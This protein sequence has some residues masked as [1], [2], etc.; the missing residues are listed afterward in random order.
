[1]HYWG[2]STKQLS[3]TNLIFSKSRFY[4]FKKH[5]GFL[6]AFI[7]HILLSIRKHH[8]LLFF[9]LLLAIFFRFYKLNQLMIF[10]GDQGWFYLSAQ[11][12]LIHHQIPLVG[13]TSSHVWLHQGPLWTYILAVL[14]FFFGFN[15]PNSCISYFPA[16]I[17]RVKKNTELKKRR[18]FPKGGCGFIF[19]RKFLPIQKPTV[20][21]TNISFR[22]TAIVLLI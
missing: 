5:F 12:M 8:I 16:L 17:I 6:Q 13:I 18:D 3:N 7:V 22:L 21:K 19:N 2:E 4:Y 11:D 1:M 15:P 9:I 14:F 10:I 20:K